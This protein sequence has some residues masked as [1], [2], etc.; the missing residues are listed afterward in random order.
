MTI[1]SGGLLTLSSSNSTGANAVANGGDV[2]AANGGT[3]NLQLG[4]AVALNV[5][6]TTNLADIQ[7]TDT[8][9]AGGVSLSATT[10]NGGPN[11]FAATATSGASD[12]GSVGVAGS[13]ALNLVNSNTSQAAILGGASV[14]LAGSSP[15]VTITAQNN[16]SSTATANSTS[17]GAGQVGVGASFAMNQVPAVTL[18]QIGDK[19]TLIRARNVTLSSTSNDTMSTS[20]Q[21]GASG[22]KVGL[23]PGVAL[24]LPTN[25]TTSSLGT[26]GTLIISGNFSE[27]A[28]HTGSTSSTADGSAAGGSAA[29][30]AAIAITV[31]NDVT[32]SSVAKSVTTGGSF[33]MNASNTASSS[34]T[35]TASAVGGSSDTS[36]GGANGGSSDVQGQVSSQ[37]TGVDPNASKD[38][39]T[40]TQTTA[41][42]NGKVGLAAAVAYNN[43]TS[44]AQASLPASVTIKS[45]GL[46]TLSSSNSTGANAVAN[47]GGVDAANG[48]TSGNGTNKLQLGAGV[49]LN[50]VNTTNLADIQGTDTITAGGV[51]LSAT[52]T[53]GGPNSF[54]ATAT[55]GASD[56]GSVGVA[57]SVALNL[58]NSNTSQAAI[59]GG[60]SVSLTG[61]S[62]D[63]T[64][65]AQNNTS[66]TATANSTSLGAGKVGVGASFAM[67]QVPAVT[68]AQIGDTVT[69]S[70]ARNVTLSSTSNDTMSTSVQTGASG[71][72]V[73]LAPGV[74]LSL[75][76]N[77]TTS[78]LGT[79]GTLIISGN[80]SETA[81]HSGSTSSTADGSAAGGSAA[82]GAAIA[83]TVGNDVT[84]SS[85]AKSVTTGGSFTLNASNTASS[86][87]TSTASAVGGSS[88]TST[89][90]ANGGSSD[91]QGQVSSQLTGVDP[92]ASK[93]SPTSTQTTA[94]SNGKV[95][96]AAAVAYN[97]VTS[98]AQASLPASVTIQSG[99]LLTLSSSNNTGANAVANGGGVDAANGGTSGNGTNKFQLGAGVALNV[100]NATNTADIQG[101]DT[102]KAGG[103]SLSATTTNG[104]PNS[105]VATAT[106]GASD[107]GSVGVA[108]SVALNLV[109]TNTNEAEE[110]SGAV[111]TLTGGDVNIIAQ[112]NTTS[113]ATANST[114]S[115]GKV[116]VGAS[117]A[118]N[119]INGTADAEVQNGATM[120]GSAGNVTV[121]ASSSNGITTSTQAGASGG[122]AGVGAA[123][124]M[125]ISIPDT[126]AIIGTGNDLK[127][128][129][130]LDI[131]STHS[132]S[133][134]STADAKVAGSGAAVGASIAIN[135]ITD[136]ATATLSRNV[137][138]GGTA[139]VAAQNSSN[140]LAVTRA[141]E[142]GATD[143]DNNSNNAPTETGGS[144]SGEVNNQLAF[145]NQFGSSVSMPD[146]S[147]LISGAQSGGVNSISSQGGGDQAKLGIAAAIAVNVI[148]STA[149]ASIANGLT[150]TAGGTLAVTSSNTNIG[151]VSADASAVSNK[152]SIGAA[153]GVDVGQITNQ[154][155]IGT[156]TNITAKGITVQATM[157][158]GQANDF[159]TWGLA[160]AGGEKTGVAASVSIIDIQNTTTANIG[161]NSTVLSTGGITVAAQDDTTIRNVAGGGAFGGST[162]VGAGI[163]VNVINSTTTADIG[164][165]V[166][167][168]AM[169]AISINSESSMNASQG[170]LAW[171][172]ANG[173]VST[174]SAM[175]AVAVGGAASTKTSVAG[176]AAVNVW[177]ESTTAFI[178][179]SAKINTKVSGASDQNIT[180]SAATSNMIA[181]GAG[182]ISAGGETGV[183]LGIDLNVLTVETHAYVNSSAQVYALGNVSV[184]AT[185]GENL[186]SLAGELTAAGS[187]SIAGSFAVDILQTNTT[188][189][190]ADPLSPSSPV[191][192][193]HAGGNFTI[194]ANDPQTVNMVTGVFSAGGS[195]GIGVSA[196]VLVRTDTV[197]ASIGTRDDIASHGS[198]GLSV[199]ANTSENVTTTAIGGSLAGGL[200]LAGS[201]DVNT[202]NDTTTAW[203][204]PGVTID[205]SSKSPGINPS[206]A[207][208]ASDITNLTST[209][210]AAAGGLDAGI[211]AGVDVGVMT[212][213][214]QAYI[215]TDT[216]TA[217]GDVTVNTASNEN[218]NSI[219]VAA[220]LGGTAAIA[221]AVGVYIFNVTTRAFIGPDP[222]G[223]GPTSGTTN[224]TANGNV[225]I[226]AVD[227]SAHTSIAGNISGS[228]TAS[229][230]AA[231]A[232]PIFNKTTEAFI[233]SGASVTAKALNGTITADNG[234]FNISYSGTYGTSPAPTAPA[235]PID[236][237]GNNNTVSAGSSARFSGSRTATPAT[238]TM[239]GV[240][241]SAVNQE[242][243][244][245]VGGSG[246]AGGVA[247]IEIS[248]VVNVVTTTTNAFI[249]QGAQIN[250][251]NSGAG[252]GQSVLVAAGDDYANM[253]FAAGVA[254]AGAVGATGDAD[255]MVIN[256]T[257]TAHVDSNAVVNARQDVTV[258]AHSTEDIF[259]L[260]AGAS[261][262]LTAGL[263]GAVTV[264]DLNDTTTA[265]LGGNGTQV[266]SGGNVALSATDDTT[267]WELSGALGLGL[268]G[269]LGGSVNVTL[270]NKNTE[271]F[272]GQNTQV[273]SVGLDILARTNE[274]VTSIAAAAGVGAFVGLG[275]GVSVVVLNSTTE[276]FIG[277]A[278]V[279]N[280]FSV[281]VAALNNVTSFTFGG[282]L[283][284]GILGIGGGVDVG[285]IENTTSAYIG[286]NA[287]VTSGGD[288]NLTATSTKNLQTFAVSA[289]GGIAALAGSVSVWNIGSD[290]TSTY[291]ESGSN[292]NNTGF[293]SNGDTSD[294]LDNNGTGL[295]AS[296]DS[297]DK[298]MGGFSGILGDYQSDG[299]PS[300]NRVQSDTSSASSTLS[301]NAPATGTEVANATNGTQVPSGTSAFIAKGAAVNARGNV[302]LNATDNLNFTTVVGGATIGFVGIGA[303]VSIVNVKG[304]AQAYIDS[305]TTVSAGLTGAITINAQVNNTLNVKTFAGSAAAGIAVSAQVG[306][307]N[308]TSVESAYIGSGATVTQA[309]SVNVSAGAN[310]TVNLEGLGASGGA[311]GATLMIVEATMSGSTTAFVGQ[312]ASI[313]A[314]AL[315]INAIATSNATGQ[316]LLAGIG[317][318]GAAGSYIP[319][320]INQDVEAYTQAGSTTTLNLSGDLVVNA[321]STISTS[322]TETVGS[323]GVLSLGGAFAN[324]T[325]TGTTKAYLGAGTIVNSKGNISVTAT[326]NNN[327]SINDQVYGGGAIDVSIA[328]A[329]VTVNDLT[330]AYVDDNVVINSTGSL[331]VNA[332]GNDVNMASASV[333]SG[334]LINGN[335]TGI[336]AAI[337]AVITAYLGKSDQINVGGSVA[338]NA[339]DAE[340]AAQATGNSVSVGAVAV[341]V[342]TANANSFVNVTAYIDTGTTVIAGESVSVNANALPGQF[343]GASVQGSGGGFAAAQAPIATTFVQFNALAQVNATLI[344][345]GGDVTIT[346]NA[347]NYSVA[348]GQ[349]A[350]D[351]AVAIGTVTSNLI[352]ME[353][354]SVA[355]GTGT[356]IQSAGNFKLAST[357]ELSAA[358][359]ANSVASGAI[360]DPVADAP[361]IANLTTTTT[362]GSGANISANTVSM[363]AV[364]ANVSANSTTT[365]TAQGIGGGSAGGVVNVHSIAT[366]SISPGTTTIIGLEGVDIIAKNDYL[367]FNGTSSETPQTDTPDVILALGSSVTA[368]SGAT[369]IA[370]PRVDGTPLNTDVNTGNLALYVNSFSGPNPPP[371]TVPGQLSSLSTNSTI[372]WCANAMIGMADTTLIID[373]SGNVTNSS[374]VNYTTNGN[375]IELQNTPGIQG[376]AYFSAPTKIT[377][378]PPLFTFSNT[379]KNVNIVNNSSKNLQIDGITV[380]DPAQSGTTNVDLESNFL[381][382]GDASNFNF[383]IAHSVGPIGGV[384][385]TNINIT[386]TGASNVILNGVINNPIGTVKIVN[387]GGDIVSAGG[388]DNIE[389]NKIN[390]QASGSIGS[391]SNRISTD[392][393]ESVDPTT[394]VVRQTQLSANATSGSVYLDVTGHLRDDV[395]TA[396]TVNATSV[397]AG[398][399]VDLLLEQS[400]KDTL[401]S[402]ITQLT[403][404]PTDGQISVLNFFGGGPSGLFTTNY[405]NSDGSTPVIT[406]DEPAFVVS[407]STPLA[408]TT[409]DFRGRDS[410]GNVTG[411][412]GLQAGGNI[413]VVAAHSSAGDPRTDIIGIVNLGGTGHIDT[414]T[415]GNITYTDGPEG[416]VLRI[417]TI[418]ST[419]R[420]VLLAVPTFL[421][422]GVALD[423]TSSG[424]ISADNSNAT[425]DLEVT[426]GVL[427]E[428][429]SLIHAGSTVTVNATG[430]IKVTATAHVTAGTS[431]SLNPNH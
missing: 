329:N 223:Y 92:S 13:V 25:T 263:S 241:V 399:N 406:V 255:V 2:D 141:G 106:S 96:L 230:G 361:I 60:A 388:G 311:V 412:I 401:G 207:V 208:A 272:V 68:L 429:N 162:G 98:T 52:T 143:P 387:T 117:F 18:A 424:K 53:N 291:N 186:S 224:V 181:D 226:S 275:G 39:P 202:W 48:G 365:A 211:G 210:G 132:G 267:T 299:S 99:G 371:V 146:A 110:K 179:Q 359:S 227:S 415:N 185:S 298:Q 373:G 173:Q 313:T 206:V 321:N 40:A 77:T 327:P 177:T 21:T 3:N 16:T 347:D 194:A 283:G 342:P 150:V 79:G 75:P 262:S 222:S 83:I 366:T 183:G 14:S 61:S 276:A 261:G 22:G 316:S 416:N 118:F 144:G 265:T 419:N 205:A 333:A 325:V 217:G 105:F 254:V 101:T 331:T 57:G 274:N 176:S 63:V 369:V 337:N 36:T 58:V 284:G 139:T 231:A 111:V 396:L 8:V 358:N 326:S 279:V 32:T 112:N 248:G 268:G 320:E 345:A 375:T 219:A 340:S 187:N 45:G 56:A 289:A 102:I 167:A 152:T 264:V 302:N 244:D 214:T 258:G 30:G 50:V 94:G 257:T 65:T 204:A 123:I 109:L 402:T 322:E 174:F 122:K 403:A 201:V 425:V 413:V 310:R 352:V 212:K 15:D 259:A 100:V 233:G 300:A 9:T 10:T 363:T 72:K 47:G 104:G 115:G 431:V 229:V 392:L 90:G 213:N 418:D 49:A 312:G 200:G 391:A 246:G 306:I 269:G 323:G 164:K 28:T 189:Y 78:S 135:A 145:A 88:D 288:V 225:Q 151:G 228:G 341:G 380:L 44:T 336:S 405:Y 398:Q 121:S 295:S 328:C 137:T 423:V 235:S 89:G 381:L 190:V 82:I 158:G 307:I 209:G 232:V 314:G 134:A 251:N 292:Q 126:T 38:S 404:N 411:D 103:L 51:S 243:L 166:Q 124:A 334:G 426:G 76:T 394:Q 408:M 170:L 175:T 220:S 31:G 318:V 199:T 113:A 332:T 19:V 281:N 54:V 384:G 245:L 364:A 64:I 131:S 309:G 153:L 157:P 191:T 5:V 397:T 41:G 339:I 368:G 163:A 182:G 271:A 428:S 353:T 195:N 11:S 198:L 142:D 108:G 147:S 237:T 242:N 376:E 240:A 293:N 350:P 125:A 427:A 308:D 330:S 343:T 86:S 354:S 249:G 116:G 357:T 97:N 286:N 73:G 180:I 297:A 304:N 107:A 356:T 114:A 46:L 421:T 29:I 348:S 24:S 127:L 155:T 414:T 34:A 362:V 338:I 154:A 355:V 1:R 317:L 383:Q 252:S 196:T 130:N 193:V 42:S 119:F 156:S 71:G 305:G 351:G 378:D 128:T 420:N 27:T 422:S 278:A 266:N 85:V 256:R 70:G 393:I 389:A 149:T 69:L 55:S 168:D 23:A 59:L 250:S 400:V 290:F 172:P 386:N 140:N 95:G 62:P 20:V 169:D 294:S 260:T 377:A 7:G 236:L 184:T 4:A 136:S 382:G 81:T 165:N 234:N 80:F 335:G 344:Q 87:A 159:R 395:N 324:T 91:V 349:S 66:S 203:I 161:D 33:T 296:T 188:A 379:P 301:S 67:N 37:L 239:S 253:G 84:T 319:V 390:L 197:T 407:S 93:D 221:G 315:S 270:L 409:Y 370:W 346:S 171:E 372:N 430:S 273:T 26:G 374:G 17:L 410:S 285:V 282:G 120:A 303:G 215:S 178:D 277:D 238:Q 287:Q 192:L 35:S 280:A 218:T 367:T 138:A 216:I 385:P 74:A 6:N 133:S 160:G 43:V 12:A 360:V 129:G 247:S 417:G 148:T